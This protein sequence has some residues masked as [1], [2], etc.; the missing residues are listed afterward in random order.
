[1]HSSFSVGAKQ[2]L[3]GLVQREQ[4]T[5]IST[6]RRIASSGFDTSG[7]TLAEWHHRKFVTPA[8]GNLP[9]VFYAVAVAMIKE[10]LLFRRNGRA[11]NR[12]GNF[13]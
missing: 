4:P 11:D 13:A 10:S 8:R 2:V 7:K 3:L 12:I 1:M 6:A 5:D 9:R